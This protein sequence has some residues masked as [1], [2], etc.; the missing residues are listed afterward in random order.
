M[1]TVKIIQCNDSKT[2]KKL[3]RKKTPIDKW[4]LE[5]IEIAVY[6]YSACFWAYSRFSFWVEAKS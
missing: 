1:D 2:L 3:Q 4:K 5:N 6:N